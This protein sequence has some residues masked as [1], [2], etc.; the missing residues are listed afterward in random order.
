MVDS[1]TVNKYPCEISSAKYKM[2]LNT[3]YKGRVT[4]DTIEV[5]TGLGGGDCGV[6]FTIGKEYVIYGKKETFIG[7]DNNDWTFPKGRNIYWVDICSRTTII[8]SEEITEI[9]KYRKKR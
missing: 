5:F 3:K 6:K 7:Q 8:N 9:E 4:A 2:T 1:T